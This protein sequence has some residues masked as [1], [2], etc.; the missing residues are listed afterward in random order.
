VFD[1][2]AA[3]FQQN[4]HNQRHAPRPP[5]TEAVQL[6]PHRYA[7]AMNIIKRRI[8]RF[9]ALLSVP[10]DAVCAE[11]GV[12]RGEFSARLIKYR[13]PRELHLIDPWKF[14]SRFPGRLY[15]GMGAKSQADM[16]AI[17]SSVAYRFSNNKR[18]VIHRGVSLE[19]AK[20]FPDDYFDYVYVDGDHSYEGA[21]ADLNA[22]FT[23]LKAGG[24]IVCDDYAW[25]D[26]N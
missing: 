14:D 16:D 21:L 20:N 12:W 23:K 24:K 10:R 17:M 19:V 4:E 13:A 8:G 18:V 22:W 6:V 1:K 5:Y 11:I 9:Y 7:T 15:G 25:V 3:K 26:E 2:P